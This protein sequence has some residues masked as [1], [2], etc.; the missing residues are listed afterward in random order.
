MVMKRLE[1]LVSVPFRG[2][3]VVIAKTIVEQFPDILFP[4][5]FGVM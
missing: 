3:V 5:P 4:S 2:Y 1:E